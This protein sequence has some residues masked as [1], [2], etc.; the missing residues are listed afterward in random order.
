MG[1]RATRVIVFVEIR[2]ALADASPATGDETAR[3]PQQFRHRSVLK[4]S[5]MR[6]VRIA[7]DS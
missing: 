3:R 2:P 1:R 7:L 6:H 4:I 5:S